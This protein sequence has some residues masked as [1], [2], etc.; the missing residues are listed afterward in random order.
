MTRALLI[1]ATVAVL[2]ASGVV[3]TQNVRR[4]GLGKVFRSL[5]FRTTPEAAASHDL[6]GAAELLDAAGVRDATYRTADL[7]RFPDVRVSTIT[8]SDY[9]LTALKEGQLF[10]LARGAV[11]QP[12][13]C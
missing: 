6:L 3:T 12:G 10:H 8:D 11:P 2:L 9:C 7:R 5:G 1:L 13:S 4:D